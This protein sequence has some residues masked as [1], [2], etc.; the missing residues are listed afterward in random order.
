MPEIQGG[1]ILCSK[2]HQ[3]IAKKVQQIF[4]I[5]FNGF[6]HAERTEHV[7]KDKSFN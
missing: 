2:M 3:L 5:I 4:A 6:S 1:N 7:R